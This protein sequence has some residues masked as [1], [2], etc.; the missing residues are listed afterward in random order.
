MCQTTLREASK[1][2]TKQLQLPVPAF[3]L[4]CFALHGAAFVLPGV[5]ALVLDDVVEAVVGLALLALN[6][7]KAN[8]WL[9]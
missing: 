2:S 7:A 5:V 9:A 8:G 6:V 4:L 1:Y 3:R